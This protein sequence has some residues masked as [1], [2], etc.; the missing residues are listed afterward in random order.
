MLVRPKKGTACLTLTLLVDATVIVMVSPQNDH[1]LLQIISRCRSRIALKPTGIRQACGGVAMAKAVP[2]AAG[3]EPPSG[4]RRPP[5]R[6]VADSGSE[7][8][9]HFGAS[10]CRLMKEASTN[11]DATAPALVGNRREQASAAGAAQ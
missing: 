3:R 6:D 11:P 4:D 9:R 7:E 5:F 8:T 2:C 10:V 1:C